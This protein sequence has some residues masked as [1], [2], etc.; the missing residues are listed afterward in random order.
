MTV[1]GDAPEPTDVPGLK[2][3]VYSELQA[4]KLI[5]NE[6][7]DGALRQADHLEFVNEKFRSLCDQLQIPPEEL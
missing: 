5:L 6:V 7:R 4:M 3:S 1:D 2:P